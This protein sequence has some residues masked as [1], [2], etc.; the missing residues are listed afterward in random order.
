MCKKLLSGAILHYKVGKV[1]VYK[2]KYESTVYAGREDLGLPLSVECHNFINAL[3][4]SSNIVINP[5]CMFCI[6]I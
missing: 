1:I 3:S 2:M 6:W 4:G 5:I